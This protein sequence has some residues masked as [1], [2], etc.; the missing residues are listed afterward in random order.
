MERKNLKKAQGGF[1][2]IEIIAVLIILGILAA[3]AVP[4]FLDMAEDSKVKAADGAMGAGLSQIHMQ[5]AQD[6]LAG[7]ATAITWTPPAGACGAGKVLGDYTMTLT[8]ACGTGGSSV[9]ITAG[10]NQPTGSWPIARTTTICGA[11]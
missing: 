9:L 5:Y 1:T 8:C 10:P 7:R 2:L 11:P 6:L 3:V 4:R